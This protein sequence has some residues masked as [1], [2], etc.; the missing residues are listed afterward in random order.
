MS[1]ELTVNQFISKLNENMPIVRKYKYLYINAGIITE[2][3]DA[4]HHFIIST[5]QCYTQ[6]EKQGKM[7][8]ISGDELEF[9]LETFYLKIYKKDKHMTDVFIDYSDDTDKNMK[10]LVIN[11]Q[12]EYKNNIFYDWDFQSCRNKQPE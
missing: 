3:R 9:N 7:L 1:Q 5:I 4:Y 2:A 12:K 10:I 11:K 8:E 6:A